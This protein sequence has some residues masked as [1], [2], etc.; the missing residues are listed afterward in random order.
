MSHSLSN[1]YRCLCA[2]LWK[3]CPIRKISSLSS[4]EKYFFYLQ[5]HVL[6]CD[7]KTVI[8]KTSVFFLFF[9]FFYFPASP[10]RAEPSNCARLAV[11][12]RARITKCMVQRHWLLWLIISYYW[13]C[14]NILAFPSEPAYQAALNAAPGEGA[15]LGKTPRHS[16][17]G[18]G[19]AG[20]GA[21]RSEGAERDPSRSCLSPPAAAAAP[22]SAPELRAALRH[23]KSITL[24]GGAPQIP[25]QLGLG[26]L[27]YSG[28]KEGVLLG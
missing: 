28:R 14:S 3:S 2:L 27:T 19:R 25:C 10:R 24:L 8:W 13:P 1:Q 12:H 5:F 11:T 7:N 4:W 18:R 21:G 15:A 26:G 22:R 9:I 6:S 20:E 17:A 16:S 23:V